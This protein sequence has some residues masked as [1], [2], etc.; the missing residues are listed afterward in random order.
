M[1][2]ALYRSLQAVETTNSATR[3]LLHSRNVSTNTAIAKGIRKDS[4][5][6]GL[7]NPYNFFGKAKANPGG[8]RFQNER[9]GFNRNRSADTYSMVRRP[10]HQEKQDAEDVELTHSIKKERLK[11][12]RYLQGAWK[13]V[14]PLGAPDR[15]S[16]S[17]RSVKGFDRRKNERPDWAALADQESRLPSTQ[18]YPRSDRVTEDDGARSNSYR[19]AA[20]FVSGEDRTG[21]F[22]T[23]TKSRKAPKSPGIRIRH[24]KLRSATNKPIDKP[25]VRKHFSDLHLKLEDRR[26][27]FAFP[28]RSSFGDEES[29]TS[30]QSSDDTDRDD[31]SRFEPENRR[32]RRDLDYE[33]EENSEEL[34]TSWKPAY[35]R[36]QDEESRSESRNRQERRAL[37]FGSTETREEPSTSRQLAYNADQDGHSHSELE[38]REEGRALEYVSMKTSEESSTRREALYNAEQDDEPPSEPKNRKERRAQEYGSV[39]EPAKV[40]QADEAPRFRM[41]VTSNLRD[42]SAPYMD[43]KLPTAPETFTPLSVP[44]TTPASEFLYGTSVVLAALRSPRRKLYKMYIYQGEHRTAVGQDRRIIKLA[45][46]QGV[47]ISRFR[48][49]GLR[50]MDKMSAGRPHNGYVL[51]AS[52]LPKLPATGLLP[53]TGHNGPITVSLDYQSRED[54]I[55]NGTDPAIHYSTTYPRYPLVLMLDGIVDP[56]NLGAIVRTAY[57]LGVD[58]IALS[59]RTSAPLTPVALKSSSGASESLPFIEVANTDAFMNAS[60]NNGWKFYATLAP[61]LPAEREFQTFPRPRK[62]PQPMG[63]PGYS[64]SS[65]AAHCP[66][67]SHPCVLMLGSEGDGIRG[68]LRRKADATVSINGSPL[69][70]GH[71]TSVVDS[72]NV[73]VAAGLLCEAFLRAPPDSEISHLPVQNTKIW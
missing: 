14:T 46:E 22:R 44:Y 16:S 17:N 70:S 65:L 54:E 1:L 21:N 48:N 19:S 18:S 61:V 29:C 52:P 8:E 66:T 30:R 3:P 27:V 69:V 10:N 6:P 51:E 71:G 32:E 38:S 58:A 9:P 62:L 15:N 25:L 20:R 57:F 4:T 39:E 60:Q 33:S 72:L 49:D 63:T 43:D 31:D 47:E 12:L 24:T 42:R 28:K 13:E 35:N 34:S 2:K 5:K 73:S 40:W 23:N 67:L 41:G 37:K 55:I 68:D 36:Y 56:G 59:S 50:L 53:V 64:L 45:D 11:Q 7:R 26:P